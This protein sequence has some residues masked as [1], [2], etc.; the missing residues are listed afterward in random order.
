MTLDE[1]TKKIDDLFEMHGKDYVIHAGNHADI[2]RAI[3]DDVIAQ[4][5]AEREGVV[6][7]NGK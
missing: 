3:N 2:L 4:M 5:E 1:A 6:S 7:E